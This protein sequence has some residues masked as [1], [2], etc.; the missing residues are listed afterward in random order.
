MKADMFSAATTL[1]LMV[2]RSPPFRQA[3]VKDPFFKRLCTAEKKA[4]WG[5]FKSIP[6]SSEF[7]DLFEKMTTRVP[8]ERFS[9]H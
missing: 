5:I 8:E 7:K 4:F 3:H 1:F 9:I 2:M 6:T